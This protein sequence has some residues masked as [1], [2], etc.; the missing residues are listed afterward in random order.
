[1]STRDSSPFSPSGGACLGRFAAAL[2]RIPAAERYWVAYSG[3]L[4]STV[5]LHA[6]VSVGTRPG[7]DLCAVHVN[8]GLNPAAAEWAE[9]CRVT[10]SRLQ[11]PL[12]LLEVDGRAGAGGGPEAAA[13][14]AR[15]DALA[16]LVQAG[17][18]LLTAHHQDDQAETVLLQLL[19]GCGPKGLAG[20]PYSARFARGWH[21][22]PLL[23]IGR[24]ELRAHA[25]REGLTWIEDSSNRDTGLRRNY[26]RH[27]VVPILQRVWPGTAGSLARSASHC[28]EAAILL[29][30]LAELDL[31][32]TAGE[33]PETLRI[34]ALRRLAPERQRNLLR[35][36][37]RRQGLPVPASAHLERLQSDVITAADDASPLLHWPGVEIRRYRGLLY[38]MRCLPRHDA[39]RI[40]P[41]AL[42]KPL[43]LPDGS[44]LIAH[45][46]RGE[47]V[48]AADCQSGSLAVRFRRGGER[49]RPA[50]ADHSRPLKK[51]LQERGV[52]PWQR[53]RLPLLYIED[54]IAAVADRWVCEPYAAGPGEEG[55][56]IEWVR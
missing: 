47:G 23:D 15:Y 50:G 2:E 17:E 41:W 8:H 13:R 33:R 5:L 31:E 34:E 24:D 40:I 4:D 44:R 16:Q 18:C 54:E 28:A 38:A 21:A 45:P 52:P 26:L 32:R 53:E 7:S 27:Q 51:L 12:T 48:Q 25:V 10:C 36:W 6:L 37:I 55:V 11:I 42:E 29:E 22:R 46:A 43:V 20:M 30:Q 39:T 56:R 49:C 1:M 14:R 35:A 3:G 19:R 9:H